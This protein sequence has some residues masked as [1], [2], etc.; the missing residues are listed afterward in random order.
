[1]LDEEQ[2][3]DGVDLTGHPDP[4][5]AGSAV[6]PDVLE[7]EPEIGYEPGESGIWPPDVQDGWA[8]WSPADREATAPPDG[9][10]ASAEW[11]PAGGGRRR[12]LVLGVVGAAILVLLVARGLDDALAGAGGRPSHPTGSPATGALSAMSRTRSAAST[13]QATPQTAGR[14]ATGSPRSRPSRRGRATRGLR[15]GPV[16]A[17]V[18]GSRPG[19]P[20]D[21]PGRAA[22]IS[23]A[24]EMQ[25]TGVGSGADRPTTAATRTIGAVRPGVSP[26]APR[27]PR[28]PSPEQEFGFER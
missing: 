25:D 16:R 19:R 21:A 13:P 28:R 12:R 1:V 10:G 18:S 22:T 14:P 4:L 17:G 8:T 23:P 9:D 7:G 24:G 3:L 2:L 15:R 6:D 20:Q 27:P 26:D 5:G 11:S